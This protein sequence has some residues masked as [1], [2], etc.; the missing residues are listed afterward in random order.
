MTVTVGRRE[1]LAALSGAAAAWPLAARAQQGERTRRV[2]VLMG[3][4]ESDAEARSK[5][6]CRRRPDRNIGVF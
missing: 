4:P 2:G 1:L 5:R 3:W 6:V